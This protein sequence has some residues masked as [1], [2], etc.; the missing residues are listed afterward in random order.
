[1]SVWS[2][3][4]RLAL[5]L[6]ALTF[7][8]L[9]AAALLPVRFDSREELFEIPQ[10]TWARRMAGDKVEILPSEIHLVVGL[11]DVLHL[12]N[13]DDVPQ[14]FG[15]TLLMPGQNFRLPFEVAAEN[16]FSCT[17][18]ASGQLEV[19]VEDA[20]ASPL[21]RLRWRAGRLARVVSRAFHREHA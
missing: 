10:G 21:D 3:S 12:R 18:H 7:V 17:A 2:R 9:A 5:P 8:P 15:P 6:A 11:H 16:V 4:R 20:P 13:L 19:I 1:M 14:I